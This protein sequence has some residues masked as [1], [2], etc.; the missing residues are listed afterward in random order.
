MDHLPLSFTG[1]GI[2]GFSIKLEHDGITGILK[3]KQFIY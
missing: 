2:Y 3:I 1:D